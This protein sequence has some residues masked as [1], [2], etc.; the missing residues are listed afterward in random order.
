MEKEVE[1]SPEIEDLVSMEETAGCF[2]DHMKSR[3]PH[4]GDN[5]DKTMGLS[6]MFLVSLSRNHNDGYPEAI[7]EVALSLTVSN[8]REAS[9]PLSQLG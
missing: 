8:R 5:A 1:S 6:F 3:L 4:G 9:K 7:V 2:C